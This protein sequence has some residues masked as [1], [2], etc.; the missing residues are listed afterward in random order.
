MEIEV[1]PLVKAGLALLAAGAAVL[2]ALSRI[3]QTSR[4]ALGIWPI[5]LTEVGIVLT[6][7]AAFAIGG[8]AP[9]GLA[10]LVT[11]RITYEAAVVALA[12]LPEDGRSPVDLPAPSMPVLPV[13]LA[14]LVGL[15]AF[16]AALP[17][18]RLTASL[19]M[20]AA[21]VALIVLWMRKDR[22][23]SLPNALLE[24]LLF[25]VLP[26]I[27]FT[28]AAARP[29]FG[30]LLLVL[31]ILVETNDSYALL[32][33]KVFGRRQ[34]FPRLSPKK[35]VEGL[36]IGAA[37]LAATAALVGTRFFGYSPAACIAIAVAVGVLS[38]AG[39]LAASRLKRVAGV[40]D[41]PLFVPRQ[42]GLLDI[43]DAWL[44]VGAVVS[45][46]IVL[47]GNA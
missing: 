27:V 32:G 40:K 20:G 22:S 47:S 23:R 8:F 18:I 2:A 30:G 28:A 26:A 11:L 38:I 4:Q 31:F 3:P 29:E 41:Y 5:Y 24:V 43:V 9:F 39:D 17:S 13:L 36:M 33:G 7:F 21:L 6:V 34:A 45:A 25:P 12:R 1:L 44:M 14:I 10:L 46:L 16:A 19:A 35:T 37:A 42:G 15:A